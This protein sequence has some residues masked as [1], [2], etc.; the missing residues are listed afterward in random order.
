MK[1]EETMAEINIFEYAAK[2]KVR[3]PYKGSITTEDLYDLNVTELDKIY[4]SLKQQEKASQ[5]ESLLETKSDAD[6]LLEVKI[7][8][9]KQ[10]VADKQAAAQAA[11]L[12][13]ET[14]ARNNR[15]KE[16]I[17]SKK[18]AALQNLSVEELE[19]MLQQ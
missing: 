14:K 15:I 5:E 3:F 16:I 9:I 19:K 12:A 1:G 13:A 7:A 6:T 4:K 10:V 17:E 8:L 18:D 11:K 2:K